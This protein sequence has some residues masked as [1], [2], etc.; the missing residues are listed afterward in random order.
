MDHFNSNLLSKYCTYLRFT[1][2]HITTVYLM[3]IIYKKY[4]EYLYLSSI[5]YRLKYFFNNSFNKCILRRVV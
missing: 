3:N 5:L 4:G 2:F 1:L